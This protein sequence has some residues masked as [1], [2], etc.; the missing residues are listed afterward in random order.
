MKEEVVSTGRANGLCA[1]SIEQQQQQ[2][3]LEFDGEPHEGHAVH[4]ELVGKRSGRSRGN[5]L[6]RE[7]QAKLEV[8]QRIRRELERSLFLHLQGISYVKCVCIF[9]F[10]YCTHSLALVVHI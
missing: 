7:G 1:V 5:R 8:G 10:I 4:H 3:T 6:E 9:I 2:Q